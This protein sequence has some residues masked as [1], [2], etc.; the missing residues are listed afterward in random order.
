MGVLQMP[1][2]E[3]QQSDNREAEEQEIRSRKEEA[4]FH[5]KQI[6]QASVLQS[7]NSLR[8]GFHAQP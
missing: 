3:A 1:A 4:N 8:I 6:K 5:Y 2:V 7:R